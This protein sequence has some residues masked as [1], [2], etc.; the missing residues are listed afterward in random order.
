MS[1]NQRTV[2]ADNALRTAALRFQT[3]VQ[4]DG[5][6]P[7][8]LLAVHVALTFSVQLLDVDRDEMGRLVWRTVH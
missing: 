2:A 8:P 5:I 6:I 3:T 4:Q 7:T 1:R